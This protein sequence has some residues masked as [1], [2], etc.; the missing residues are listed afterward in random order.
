MKKDDI[1]LIMPKVDPC[2]HFHLSKC[3]PNGASSNTLTTLYGH[4]YSVLAV[5]LRATNTA[6]CVTAP[7]E[8]VLLGVLCAK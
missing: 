6:G 7:L 8:K 1:L 3:N 2:I 5:Q 4:S